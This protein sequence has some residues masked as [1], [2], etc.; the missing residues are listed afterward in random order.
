MNNFE[1]KII[2]VT[3]GTG[4]F[5]RYVVKRLLDT[6]VREIRVFSRDE[7]KQFDMRNKFSS[8]ERITFML[9]DIR[10]LNAVRK[11]M[12]GVNAVFH[13]AALKQVPHCE[14][15]P[16][17][18]VMTNIIGANNVITSALDERVESVVC[19]STD[20]AVKPVN[21]MG[22]TKALQEK[23]V[24]NANQDP[25]NRGTRFVCVRYGNVL[26]SRGSVVPFFRS[27][28]HRGRKLTITNP[29]M[30]R[31]MLTLKQAVEL[32]IWAHDYAIG[33]E[34]LVRRCPSAR[35][36]DIAR[37]VCDIAEKP[38]EYTV[39]GTYPGEKVH[40]ILISDEEQAR[41]I[42]RDNYF[43]IQPWK[44]QTYPTALA[45]EYNSIDN[46]ISFEETRSLIQQS[47]LESEGMEFEEGYFTR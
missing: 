45:R 21:V 3:G 47:D 10:D 18:A 26:N 7:K 15:F 44:Q 11:A 43:V 13:A 2:L 32:V 41:C 37:A 27:C 17:E 22:L 36:I 38:F 8:D 5:G 33:G 24:V 19:I 28:L 12:S 14:K 30:T 16:E 25:R 40:E 31:F 42:E 20:K 35:I 46:L 4:S 34:T 6:K 29:E 39:I 23:I 9:G 1:D